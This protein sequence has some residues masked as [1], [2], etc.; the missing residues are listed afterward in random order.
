MA[1]LAS[2]P[3][4]RLADLERIRGMIKPRETFN[5]SGFAELLGMTRPNLRKIID[6]DPDF[7]VKVRGSEGV[8]WVLSGRKTVAHLT[9]RAKETIKRRAEK[10]ERLATLSGLQFEADDLA[11]FTVDELLKANVASAATQKRKIEQGRLIPIAQHN[12]II[13]SIMTTFQNG[14]RAVT[15]R[16][17][18][19][20]LMPPELRDL[21]DDALRDLLVECH[22]KLGDIAENGRR[23]D[24]AV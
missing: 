12:Q 1:R 16:L 17:D 20:G 7:P 4:Q 10:A 14:V 8:E 19:A 18:E 6:A 13:S 15:P 21:M 23:A 22:D 5:L 11:H 9:K 3:K 2:D 24:S